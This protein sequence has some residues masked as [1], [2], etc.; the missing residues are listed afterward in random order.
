MADLQRAKALAESMTWTEVGVIMGAHPSTIMTLLRRQGMRPDITKRPPPEPR[1]AD[2]LRKAIAIRN[3]EHKSW[4]I[5]AE[6]IDWPLGAPRSRHRS[7]SL[8]SS[9]ARYCKAFGLN[10]WE[11]PPKQRYF[12][13]D[14]KE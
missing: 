2:V 13:H 9:C 7:T 1:H 12:K 3:T 8:R 10:L 6:E 11:G 14:P 5:I 4:G